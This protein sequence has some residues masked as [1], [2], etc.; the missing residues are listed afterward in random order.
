MLHEDA[1][2]PAFDST[3]GTHRLDLKFHAPRSRQN[4]SWDPCSL[5]KTLHLV[6]TIAQASSAWRPKGKLF[7]QFFCSKWLYH[8]HNETWPAPRRKRSSL[9][10][11]S[12]G[13]WGWLVQ[14][15]VVN[16]SSLG[17]LV[18]VFTT[19]PVQADARAE[20]V[21][22]DDLRTGTDSWIWSLSP[23]DPFEA[24]YRSTIESFGLVAYRSVVCCAIFMIFLTAHLVLSW[25]KKKWLSPENSKVSLI[26]WFP[27][28][29]FFHFLYFLRIFLFACSTNMR[30]HQQK[31]KST[32][33]FCFWGE[34]GL[35][36]LSSGNLMWFCKL[37]QRR[38]SHFACCRYI[39]EYC[40]SLVWHWQ[41]PTK[42]QDVRSRSGIYWLV[43]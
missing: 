6:N 28:Q 32:C 5:S 20:F 38:T 25:K 11:F 12:G 21:T 14:G 1:V 4:L 37:L 42:H 7:N 39:L 40:P 13:G 17:L 29:L 27:P 16:Q 19:F 18:Q 10:F 34:R 23:C 8:E 9:E 3:L 30:R 22:R 15:P 41:A 31:L 24:A 35:Y 36:S 43:F 2:C 33:C 26:V